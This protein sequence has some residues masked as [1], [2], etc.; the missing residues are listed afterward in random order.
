MVTYEVFVEELQEALYRLYDPGY[1]PP[2]TLCQAIGCD[3][4]EGSP[5]VRA[6]IL[7]AIVSLEPPPTTPPTAETRQI[8]E[9]LHNRF[10]LR[11]T[12][13]ETA[14]RLNVSR[15]TVNR[16]QQRAVHTLAGT[17]WERRQQAQRSASDLA[18]EGGGAPVEARAAGTQA[19]DWDS[20]WQRELNSL[21]A[22]APG[23]L[24]DVAEAIESALGFIDA[25]S[26]GLGTNI[27]VVSVQPGLVADVH[28][29]L[30]HQVLISALTRLAPRI[31]NG[32][33][34]VYARLEDGN[35]RV[36]LTGAVA[37]GGFSEGTL[38]TGIPTSKDVKI[39]ARQEGSQAFVW[40]T[41]P[42]VG[43]LTVLAVDDNEDM[44][45]FYRDC[46]IGT[47]YHV[48]HIA[49]GRDLAEAVKT[50]VPDAIVLD[51]MLPDI[52]GWRLLMRLHEDPETR[53]IPVVVCTVVR[54]EDLALSLGAA[55]FL[56]KPVRPRQFIQALDRVCPQVVAGGPTAP[57]NSGEA[58]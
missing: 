15:R 51:V 9:L 38:R 12:Q 24:S 4:Q 25:W 41:A 16:L 36:T 55:C 10:E 48:V 13:E 49:Q 35:A 30:L 17:L 53:S 40:I 18:R 5:A 28:P 32:G 23:A 1:Q 14:Y 3:P 42:S 8:Y 58:G 43:K 20:Q 52:D 46:A 37:A 33:I 22:K 19:P 2:D 47:R 44:A 21:Q 26:P 50:L 45:R 56:S 34:A 57:A 11:L 27:R 31:S 29:V 7:H 39:E 54:E 6:A